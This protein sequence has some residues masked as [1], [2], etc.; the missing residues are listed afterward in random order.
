[1]NGFFIGT[2]HIDKQLLCKGGHL[3]ETPIDNGWIGK[4]IVV[5]INDQGMSCIIL[6]EMSV[7]DSF[8]VLLK[9]FRQRHGFHFCQ[10][11]KFNA[12]GINSLVSEGRLYRL[13]VMNTDGYFF[14]ITSDAKMKLLLHVHK[15]C[16]EFIGHPHISH[17]CRGYVGT[18]FFDRGINLSDNIRWLKGIL[19]HT[20]FKAK[21]STGCTGN[22]FYRSKVRSIRKKLNTNRVSFDLVQIRADHGQFFQQIF[23]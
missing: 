5:G 8:F 18:N 2:R 23:L 3:G 14:P 7:G 11:D 10:G 22:P 13:I 6:Q 12:I 19:F 9:N 15:G 21:K 20:R 1:M 16:N 17:E 4:H